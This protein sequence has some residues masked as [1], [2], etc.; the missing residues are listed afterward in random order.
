MT[1]PQ[2]GFITT[3]EVKVTLQNDDDQVMYQCHATNPALNKNPAMTTV[4]LEVMYP[5]EPP[6]ITG[7]TSGREV[8]AEA[9]QSM[10]CTSVGGN[11]LATLTWWKGSYG[12]RYN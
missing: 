9:I 5:P 3:S 6:I 4:T 2:G 8:T 1:F 12:Y 7:Y 11:P 10:L